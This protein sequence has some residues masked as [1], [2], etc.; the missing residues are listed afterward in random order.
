MAQERYPPSSASRRRRHPNKNLV[1][2]RHR[3][4]RL[5]V[6]CVGV[7]ACG[8]DPGTCHR[9][10]QRCCWWR[11][12]TTRRWPWWP[13]RQRRQPNG[14]ASSRSLTCCVLFALSIQCRTYR[15]YAAS[16]SADAAREARARG[17]DRE[18]ARSHQHIKGKQQWRQRRR[19]LCIWC[20]VYRSTGCWP[21]HCPSLSHRRSLLSR[22]P[23][24]LET[25]VHRHHMRASMEHHMRASM[26]PRLML[27][28][29]IP[30]RS[31]TQT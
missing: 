14:P 10:Q 11:P 23:L 18:R 24:L 13:R 16:P 4:L 6:L 8:C 21:R 19:L 3:K 5:L 27:L 30:R 12:T 31:A 25:S 2:R 28:P 20:F 15:T 7:G 1:H 29:P 17:R 9:R 22:L 26:E